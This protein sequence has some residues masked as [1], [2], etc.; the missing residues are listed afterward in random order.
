MNS[1]GVEELAAAKGIPAAGWF[2]VSVLPTAEAFEPVVALQE[3]LLR[4]ALLLSLLVA[5]AGWWLLSRILRQQFAPM[6]AASALL[7]DRSHSQDP[8]LLQAMPTTRA[9][10]VGQLMRSFNLLRAALAQR[11]AAL[12]ESEQHYRTLADGGLARI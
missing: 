9:D 4:A 5:T 7:A 1:R 10:E 11:E 6:L 8:H 3:R 12:Q 2:L